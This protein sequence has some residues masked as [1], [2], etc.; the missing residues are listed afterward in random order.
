VLRAGASFGLLLCLALAVAGCGGGGSTSS[1]EATSQTTALR[2]PKPP[3]NASPLVHQLY[4]SFQPPRADPE[5]SGSAKAIKAGEAAC[6]GKTPLQVKQRF[7]PIAVAKGALDPKSAQGK[8]IAGVARFEKSPDSAYTAGQL[9]GDAY[10]ATLE[11]EAASYG[12][13]GCVYGLARRLEGRLAP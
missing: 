3:K 5:V 2:G 6:E 7:F 4:R 11:G 12:Y 1:T 8:M 13:Q 10:E 9:A